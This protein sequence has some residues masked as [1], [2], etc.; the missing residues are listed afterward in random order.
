M[1]RFLIIFTFLQLANFL[2]NFYN[3]K[4][5]HE[6]PLKKNLNNE[7]NIFNPSLIKKSENNETIFFIVLDGMMSLDNAEKLD[8]I[9]NK[10]IEKKFLKKNKLNYLKIL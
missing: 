8:I 1:V 4:I 7:K 3:H 10:E 5:D 2:I 6:R 9:D